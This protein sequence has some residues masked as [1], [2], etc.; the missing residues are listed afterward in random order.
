MVDLFPYFFLIFSLFSKHTTR[1]YFTLPNI[2]KLSSNRLGMDGHQDL[3]ENIS[4][5]KQHPER[6]NSFESELEPTGSKDKQSGPFASPQCHFESKCFFNQVR[7]DSNINYFQ[8]NH[9]FCIQTFFSE[10]KSAGLKPLGEKIKALFRNA[11]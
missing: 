11:L 1:R 7:L 5:R 6:E 4:I 9:Y 10:S 2:S 8:S 3:I